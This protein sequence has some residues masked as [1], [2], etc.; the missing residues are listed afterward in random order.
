MRKSRNG[1]SEPLPR[2]RKRLGQHHLTQGHLCAPLIDFLQPQGRTV[3]EIGPGGG[4]LTEQLLNAGARVLAV[5][6]DLAWVSVTKRRLPTRDL[7]L[8]VAD[9]L[10]LDWSRFPEGTLV[11]GNLPFAIATRLIDRILD[12]ADTIPKAGFMLQKEVADRVLA[13]PRE[14]AY[15]ALTITTTARAIPSL[16][17]RIA[18]GSFYPRPEVGASFVGF[19]TRRPAV[20]W[21]AWPEFV[22]LV[23][24]AF[25]QRRKQLRNVLAG[26]LEKRLATEALSRASLSPSC[27]AEELS[28]DDFIRLYRLLQDGVVGE[29]SIEE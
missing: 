21:D 25:S 29:G 24:L 23:Q 10:D 20:G 3:V 5:E 26:T 18:A 27:R 28:G 17:S 14:K 15:G 12:Q 19:E 7:C 2:Y 4:V 11:A 16:L 22:E 8:I 9:A 13:V 6:L 1:A